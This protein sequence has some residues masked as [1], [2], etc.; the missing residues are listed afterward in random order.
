[1]VFGFW[2]FVRRGVDRDRGR[3]RNRQTGREKD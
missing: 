2:C 3:D 1:M